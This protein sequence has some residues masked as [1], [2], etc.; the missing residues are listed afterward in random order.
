VD[1]SPS[2]APAN[3]I[4]EDEPAG[5]GSERLW[6]ELSV[7]VEAW[8]HSKLA[9]L[10]HARRGHSRPG[11][12]VAFT[13]PGPVTGRPVTPITATERTGGTKAQCADAFRGPSMQKSIKGRQA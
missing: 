9:A 7:L 12:D 8:Q 5:R 13:S 4:G 2:W 1:Y 10:L 3:S 11:G 6:L